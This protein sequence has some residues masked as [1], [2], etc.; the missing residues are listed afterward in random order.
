MGC[1][2]HL[3]AENL[4]CALDGERSDIITQV[5]AQANG[6][7]SGFMACGLDNA[8]G[9]FHRMLLRLFDDFGGATLSVDDALLSFF[10]DL[11]QFD[12][13]ALFGHG[14]FMLA[15]FCCSEALGG[16]TNFMVNIARMK[17]TTNCA[18]NVAFR[19]TVISFSN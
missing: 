16:H 9:F 13:H 19:F 8:G 17:K 4:L 14:Q 7:R 11:L 6:L 5:I 10:M 15:A 12:L 18:N 2:V 3:A 1:G